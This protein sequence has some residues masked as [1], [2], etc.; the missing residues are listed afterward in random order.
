MKLKLL[1]IVYFFTITSLF[2]YSFTQMDLGIP[3]TGH[4]LVR[5]TQIVFQN[6]GFFHR[7]I[8]SQIYLAII[9]SL[10]IC[11]LSFLYFSS[12]NMIKRRTL[13]I[14]ILLT[15]G[16]LTLSYNAFSKDIFNYIFDSKILIYYR[17]NP[18][19]HNALNYPNDPMLSFLEWVHRPYPYGPVWLGLTG[20]LYFLG[21][22]R[23]IPT[24]FLFKALISIFF[25]GTAYFIDKLS[26]AIGK[27]KNNHSLIFFALNPLILIESLV[28]SHND[29]VMI[30]FAVAGVYFLFKSKTVFGFLFLLFSALVK[31]PTMS[32]FLP[33]I[34]F[35]APKIKQFIRQKEYF[36]RFCILSLMAALIYFLLDLKQDKVELQPWYLVWFI[37]FAAFLKPNKFTYFAF[38]GAS[39]LLLTKYTYTLY[40]GS[41]ALPPSFT[42]FKLF[43]KGYVPL[44]IV[45]ATL[46]SLNYRSIIKRL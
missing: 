43:I 30:F 15:T 39:F 38:V 19:L 13:W 4:K 45:A 27:D 8:S 32:L 20:P 9:A 31:T 41:W 2:L 3:L 1:Y 14:T 17:E 44:S 6:I 37:P 21:H 33:F 16:L 28:S 22:D 40:F 11:Y 18:Y 12:K 46:L 5:D 10:F 36:F 26:R 7:D 42:L 24:F 23:L 29:I 34:L 25:L 35:F